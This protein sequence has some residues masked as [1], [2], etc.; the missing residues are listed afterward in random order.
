M[1][2]VV[3]SYRF[4]MLE[5]KIK[6]PQR[7]L[8]RMTEESINKL[9]DVLKDKGVSEELLI[10]VRES[11]NLTSASNLV[12]NSDV[13]SRTLVDLIRG[14]EELIQRQEETGE[15]LSVAISMLLS[16]ARAL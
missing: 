6:I 10:S 9:C 13:P 14:A 15:D 3:F 1:A 7:H 8:E 16:Q 4:Y 5:E 11:R 12:V 2:L